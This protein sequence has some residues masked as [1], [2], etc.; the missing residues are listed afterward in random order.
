MPAP[1]ARQRSTSMPCGTSST[2]ICPAVI[3]S[4]LEVGV[5]GRTE[6][7][8]ISFLICL[9]SARIWPRIAPGSPRE[10]QTT[11]RFFDPFSRSARIRLFAK[12]CATPKPAMATAD[13]SAMSATAS[14]GDAT[15]LSM[16]IL[17]PGVPARP[18]GNARFA[19]YCAI[20]P[21]S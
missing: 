17:S 20:E 15:T 10:L 18:A 3:C 19:S 13:P 1:P 21:V 7:A 4:S 9:F 8:A 12:R 2:S 16:A 14:V 11:V 5:P 6:N